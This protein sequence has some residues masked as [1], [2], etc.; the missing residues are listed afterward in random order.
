MTKHRNLTYDEIA[1]FDNLKTACL[2]F[3]YTTGRY[4]T[5]EVMFK[6]EVDIS[7]YLSCFE[8]MEHEVTTRRQRSNVTKVVFKNVPL[9]IPD[10]EIVHLCETYG[11][12]TDYTVHYEKLT[13]NRNKGMVGGTRYMEVELFTGASMN[14]FYWMEGPLS[15]DTGSRVT[16]LH[17]GQVQQCSNC[18]KLANLGCP[19]K[20]NGKACVALGTPRTTMTTYMD[21][22]KLKHGYRSLKTMYYEKY[23]NLGGAGSCGISENE[24]SNGDE[25]DIVPINPIEEKDGQIADLKKALEECQK[26][27]TDI[28]VIKDTLVKTRN[29]LKFSKKYTAVSKRKI[30]FARKITEQRMSDCLLVPSSHREDELI[31]LYYTLADEDSFKLEDDE[32]V[33]DGDFLK[34]VEEQLVERGDCPVERNRLD[35]VRNKI[36]DKLKSK[37]QGRGRR[38]SISSISSIGSLK[39]SGEDQLGGDSVR[40]RAESSSQLP[41]PFK[42][43]Q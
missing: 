33:P 3:N 28:N 34:D 26:E 38:D 30:D 25:E 35:Q 5:R 18:L 27:L 22:I 20:G 24:N 15:G 23:P 8:F 4:D 17:P 21:F 40:V 32:I 16:V 13:N 37:K 6:P 7:P 39:R 41:I 9:N 19:G 42:A 1:T 10:E 2:R 14:N 12:P 11:K 43:Q 31:N 36:L 29:E